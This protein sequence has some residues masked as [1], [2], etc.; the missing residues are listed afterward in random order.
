MPST[1]TKTCFFFQHETLAV[2]MFERL[3][4]KNDMEAEFR[5]YGLKQIDIKFI[6]EQIA[7]SPMTEEGACICICIC[8]FKAMLIVK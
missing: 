6:K 4:E 5:K 7:G 2:R 3:V 1:L 8:V